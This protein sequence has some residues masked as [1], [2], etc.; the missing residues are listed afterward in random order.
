MEAQMNKKRALID[1]GRVNLKTMS[2]DE[3]S[4]WENFCGALLEIIKTKSEKKGEPK[5]YE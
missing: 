1:K 3:I 4:H 2:K 5:Q